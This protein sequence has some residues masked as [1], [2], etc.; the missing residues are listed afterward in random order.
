MFCLEIIQGLKKCPFK[1]NFL[2]HGGIP[3][4]L[5]VKLSVSTNLS[6]FSAK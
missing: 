4:T 6:V 1:R 3:Y 2:D 5:S